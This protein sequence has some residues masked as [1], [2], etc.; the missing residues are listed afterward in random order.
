MKILKLAC[1]MRR[2]QDERTAGSA[3][4]DL[5]ALMKVDVSRIT[6]S[7][8]C[9]FTQHQSTPSNSV[10]IVADSAI[11]VGCRGLGWS[12]IAPAGM[13]AC[14]RP[15]SEY[16]TH[17]ARPMSEYA[18]S[19]RLCLWIHPCCNSLVLPRSDRHH[20]PVR[21]HTAPVYAIA[22]DPWCLHRVPATSARSR[23]D[24]CDRVH[25]RV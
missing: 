1:C 6:T 17:T 2:S 9:L 20:M 4:G 7:Y 23:K 18:C 13:K 16:C 12:P 15:V 19:I 11:L 25:P 21:V 3:K 8:T 10:K 5:Q 24:R 22:E 14:A